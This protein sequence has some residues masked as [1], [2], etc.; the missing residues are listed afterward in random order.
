MIDYKDL[1]IKYI[2]HVGMNE[3]VSFLDHRYYFGQ[4]YFSDD[5]W[6][7]LQILD[8]IYLETTEQHD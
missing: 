2:N 8:K 1:L 7:E 6:E 5:E 4:S 3:G